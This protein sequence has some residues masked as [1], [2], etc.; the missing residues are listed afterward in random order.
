[1]IFPIK[2]K[3]KRGP[4]I[5]FFFYIHVDAL[6]LKKKKHFGKESRACLCEETKPRL[7]FL[8]KKELTDV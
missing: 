7:N 3:Y 8:E 5:T 4:K 1:M 6:K 2:Q